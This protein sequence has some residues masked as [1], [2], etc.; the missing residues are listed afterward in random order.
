MQFIFTEVRGPNPTGIELGEI[1]L[2]GMDMKPVN[3]LQSYQLNCFGR[4]SALNPASNLIDGMIEEVWYDNAGFGCGEEVCNGVAYVTIDLPRP[5]PISYYRLYTGQGDPTNDPTAWRFGILQ[6]SGEFVELSYMQSDMHT[7]PTERGASYELLGAYTPPSPP[8]SPLPPAVPPPP[9]PP[10]HP[11]AGPA[12]PFPPQPPAAPPP[13][14]PPL[15][16]RSGRAVDGPLG[17]CT[18]FYDA[19]GDGEL[20]LDEPTPNIPEG[21][22]AWQPGLTDSRQPTAGNY[23][24]N[25]DLS[26]LSDLPNFLQPEATSIVLDPYVYLGLNYSLGAQEVRDGAPSVTA[27]GGH[28]LLRCDNRFGRGE[29]TGSC[30]CRDRYTG[31]FQRLKLAS[32]P[33]GGMISPLSQLFVAMLQYIKDEG[34]ETDPVAQMEL[35]NEKLNTALGV[36]AEAPIGTEGSLLIREADGFAKLPEIVL[37]PPNYDPYA[38]MAGAVDGS[39]RYDGPVGLRLLMGMAKVSSLAT[40]LAYILAGMRA[41]STDLDANHAGQ[42]NLA[43]REEGAAAYHALAEI[44]YSTTL[45]ATNDVDDDGTLTDMLQQALVKQGRRLQQ[46]GLPAA[47]AASL[48]RGMSTCMSQ[49]D[50]DLV[51]KGVAGQRTLP[52]EYSENSETGQPRG[53]DGV[54]QGVPENYNSTR[55]LPEEVT[56]L[57]ELTFEVTRTAYVCNGMLPEMMSDLVRGVLSPAEF[58]AKLTP[59]EFDTLLSDAEGRV[60]MQEGRTLSPQPPPLPPLAPPPAKPPPPP[61]T[62]VPRAEAEAGQ[63]EVPVEHW[64]PGTILG[65]LALIALI[66]LGVVYHLSGGAVITYLRLMGSHSNPSVVAGYLP[67]DQR[68]KMRAEVRLRKQAHDDP[69]VFFQEEQKRLEAERLAAK[70]RERAAKEAGEDGRSSCGSVTSS[71]Y[72]VAKKE[73][74]KDIYD[75]QMEIKKS[76][77]KVEEVEQDPILPELG[78]EDV[79]AVQRLLQSA[80]NAQRA[81]ILAAEAQQQ[82]ALAADDEEARAAAAEDRLAAEAAA[83]RLKEVF[84]T[85]QQY[86]AQHAF[87]AAAE[88]AAR[89]LEAAEDEEDEEALKLEEIKVKMEAKGLLAPQQQEDYGEIQATYGYGNP[90]SPDGDGEQGG[91]DDATGHGGEAEEGRRRRRRRGKPSLAEADME[92]VDVEDAAT[93]NLLLARVGAGLTDIRG[94]PIIPVSEQG[95]L[96]ATTPYQVQRCFVSAAEA[97]LK[98]VEETEKTKKKSDKIDPAKRAKVR[99]DFSAKHPSAGQLDDKV[100]DLLG[101]SGDYGQD[102]ESDDGAGAAPTQTAEERA[103]AQLDVIMGRTSAASRPAPMPSVLTAQRSAEL[104]LAAAAGD[105]RSPETPGSDGDETEQEQARRVAWIKHYIKLGDYDRAIELG[106]DGAPPR[107]HW[108]CPAPPHER[109][110]L[111]PPSATLLAPPH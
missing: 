47:E 22:N 111:A 31:L 14:P 87:V 69:L 105:A 75:M 28:L 21:G 56:A 4:C 94:V 52:S 6:P 55:I 77:E 17:A 83:E 44:L 71:Q 61:A 24:I 49:Y 39:D 11:P 26:P 99:S 50:S 43:I 78:L 35:A 70:E 29:V 68:D 80:Y 10:G 73:K 15:F 45:N 86:Q 20:G 109:R 104:A 91:E 30:A 7:V 58:D 42:F 51:Y 40:Q 89:A 74:K 16:T 67:K 72:A 1:V 32:V 84:A 46:S 62:P 53:K 82:G 107:P 100:A 101:A 41:N 96:A 8:Q 36:D 90:D 25:V 79:A 66:F 54:L 88:A 76:K 19:D 9:N 48:R 27:R 95:E 12:P 59:A 37:D 5:E 93:V 13:T 57:Q 110:R 34:D 102:D 60:L 85:M 64:L 92:G 3:A 81:F 65:L 18:A 63:T 98:A 38:A 103:R 106:W 97:A 108:R 33:G 2:Y 23:E